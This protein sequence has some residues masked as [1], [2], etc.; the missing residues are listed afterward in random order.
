MRTSTRVSLAGVTQNRVPGAEPRTGRPR[1]VQKV[2]GYAVAGVEDDA[3][4]DGMSRIGVRME[5]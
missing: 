5:R 2:D 1:I 4:V 3:V